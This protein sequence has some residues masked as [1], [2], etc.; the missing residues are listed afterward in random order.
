MYLEI[1]SDFFGTV[2]HAHEA[3][4]TCFGTFYNV[5]PRP[6]IGNS[7]AIIGTLVAMSQRWRDVYGVHRT[8]RTV[9][10]VATGP[11]TATDLGRCAESVEPYSD[12]P[13]DA[14]K[15]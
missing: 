1:T 11:V 4:P 15:A 3:K 6:V 12:L 14:E 7:V 9:L 8:C 10:V 5:E 13:L 2:L